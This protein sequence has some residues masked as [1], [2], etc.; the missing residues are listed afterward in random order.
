MK[1]ARDLHICGIVQ[2]VGFRPFVYR[3]ATRWG[4]E[5]WVLNASDGVH[6]HLEG[7]AASLEGFMSELEKRAPAAARIT[8]LEVKEGKLEG[9]SGQGGFAIRA[10]DEQAAAS[11]L[12]SP[13]IATCPECLRELFDPQDRRFHYP[14][15]NCTNCGPRFTIIDALPY[16]RPN[17]SMAPFAMCAACDKEYRDPL[18]RRFHAQPDACFDC[19]PSL[20]LWLSGARGSGGQHAND[21]PE[22]ARNEA[23]PPT[24]PASAAFGYASTDTQRAKSDALIE[25]T[26]R[27]LA[28]GRIVAIKGLGGYHLA[29]DATNE[30]AVALLRRRKRR[31]AKPF[32]LM[33]RDLAGARALCQVTDQEAALL[34]GTVRPIVLLRRK[35]RHAASSP[36]A[37]LAPSV[38]GNLHELGV[39]LPYTPV[40][41]L[42]MAHMNGPLVM[43]SGNISEEPIIAQ[44]TEAHEL[45]G[46]VADAFL[47]NDRTIL[48][49]YDDSVVRV[50]DEKTCM[51]RRARGYAPEPLP[52]PRMALG[53]T[54]TTE[55]RPLILSVGP[56]QKN[57]FCF[58]RNE[59]AFC[60]QHLGDLESASAFEAW[61]ATLR[62]YQRLFDLNYQIV[63][64]DTHPEYLSTKWARARDEARIEVQHH[65]AHI[66]SVL[67][68]HRANATGDAR[69]IERVIGV[70]FDGTGYGDDGTLWGGEVLIAGLEDFE[71]FAHLRP[72]PLPGGKAAIEHPDRMA[73][74]YL[75]TL[76]LTE[77]RGAAELA[78]A[79]GADRLLL[80]DQIIAGR[81]NTPL[82]SSMGRL[83]DAVSALAGVC[84]EGSYEGQAAV[85]LE[86]ALYDPATGLPT[87]DLAAREAA[88][89][90]HFSLGEG[91][92]PLIIDPTPV[93]SALLDDR[94]AHVPTA[95]I[96]LRFHEAVVF[97]IAEVC[98]QARVQT[99]LSTVALSGGVFMNR[100][101]LSRSIPLLE[102]EGFT[103]LA[104]RQLP[105][106]DGCISYGQ[107]AVAA[108]RVARLAEEGIPLGT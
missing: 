83:F 96:S 101:L 85:E 47:D 52:F 15:I 2:G 5:G 76:G 95:L 6:A 97:L 87:L 31:S 54:S 73:W 94:A 43:T 24:E 60:S 40:Q 29:C 107:A 98:D 8:V 4:L 23:N 108:A 93:L 38:A 39:M 74:S 62:L 37:A 50:I 14:F 104:N 9:N 81:I 75:R 30:E 13:D 64:C 71:R 72:V 106:N 51:I 41:H 103:V 82:S 26:A 90:Y 89:R 10:S 49:R 44:E 17:T 42:L 21:G 16:D 79:L 32:A 86:T 36:G 99:G 1:A 25:Q 12:V 102:S 46:G 80:L 61:R 19:G 18:D 66:A 7:D 63:A 58:V 59:E 68:E 78:A 105:A 65:H 45:L 84:L 69:L 35:P 100:Y 53:N 28:A 55:H 56:E 20:Q 3:Q 33:V 27:L 67:A 70:A 91:Q 11:T 34:S 88:E 92:M 77:R 57:T 22:A 48:S